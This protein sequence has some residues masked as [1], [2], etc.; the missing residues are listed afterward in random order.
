MR[1]NR[2]EAKAAIES[3]L[4]NYEDVK[5]EID[6]LTDNQGSLIWFVFDNDCGIKGF[7]YIH[8]CGGRK[9]KTVDDL[10]WAMGYGDE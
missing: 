5:V 4:A 10:L 8:S 7:T 2:A 9:I 1:F 6:K 3:F